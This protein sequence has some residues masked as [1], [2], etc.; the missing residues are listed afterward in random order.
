MRSKATARP[1]LC[2]SRELLMTRFYQ[3]LRK[4]RH[5]FFHSEERITTDYLPCYYEGR[6]VGHRCQSLYWCERCQRTYES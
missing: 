4:L 3:V 6:I 1:P 5:R 2:S